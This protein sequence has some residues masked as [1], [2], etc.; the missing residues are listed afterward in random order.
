MVE[1]G[2]VLYDT[3]TNQVV[4]YVKAEAENEVDVSVPA[5]SIDPLCEKY[6]WI[7]PYVYCAN[8]PIRYV[9]YRGDRISLAGMQGLVQAL[10]TNYTQTIV[11]DLQA[12]T[13]LTITVGADGKMSYAKDKNGKT[14]QV[15]SATARTFMTGA[16]DHPMTII[17]AHP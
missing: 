7:S 12:Q 13:G 15:G 6:P 4:G 16:I 2:S 9:D 17:I 10:N 11:N 3:K 5:M 8:N 1:I 14:V